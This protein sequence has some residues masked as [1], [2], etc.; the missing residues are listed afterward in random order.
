[1]LV[2]WKCW[3]CFL[4]CYTGPLLPGPSLSIK[5]SPHITFYEKWGQS[6]VDGVTTLLSTAIAEEP[7]RRPH[8]NKLKAVWVVLA[9]SNAYQYQTAIGRNS[10]SWREWLQQ[11]SECEAASHSS[12]WQ[13]LATPSPFAYLLNFPT[14]SKPDTNYTQ[15]WLS[16]LSGRIW[17]TPFIEE[18]HAGFMC[19]SYA[20]LCIKGLNE[21][22]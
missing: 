10:E 12:T 19:K 4:S 9:C 2:Y 20:N 11:R 16:W 8:K 14:V 21:L 3:Y 6:F 18:I 22:N 13:H 1:M 5:I 15:R 17:Q 7:I